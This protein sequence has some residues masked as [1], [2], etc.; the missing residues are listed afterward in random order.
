MLTVEFLERMTSN[1]WQIYYDRDTRRNC[2]D[3][4]NHYDNSGKLTPFFENT[5]ILKLVSKGE[6]LKADYF[7]V[8]SH[9]VQKHHTRKNR[10]G[11]RLN[12]FSL[13]NTLR[14]ENAD[15][16]SFFSGRKNTNILTQGANYHHPNYQPAVELLLNHLGLQYP[17]KLNFVILF[18][19][20]VMRSQVYQEYV[21]S[22]LRPA[23]EFMSSDATMKKLLMVN[24]K[25]KNRVNNE[26]KKAGL[27]WYPLHPFICERLPSVFIQQRLRNLKCV[28]AF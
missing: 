25:Y 27:Q 17:R 24:A 28:Q 2:V 1:I 15:V 18:N 9:D 14:R 23:M 12:P 4:W 7:G 8:F 21:D 13:D 5:P 20:F 19:H 10:M 26:M 11:Q 16:V 3:G 6:H 22:T